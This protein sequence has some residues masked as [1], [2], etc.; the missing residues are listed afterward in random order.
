MQNKVFLNPEGFL[1]IVFVGHQT[2]ETFQDVYEK[3]LPLL[4]GMKAEGT[5]LRGLF[6]LTLQT[7]YSLNSDKAAM[8]FLEETDYDRVAMYHVPHAEVT[9]AIILA[10]GKS[11]NTKL[12]ESREEALAWLMA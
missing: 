9:K 3:V 11:D 7:G 8:K 2:G 1:E 10:M 12:F 5:P 6:D 4:A